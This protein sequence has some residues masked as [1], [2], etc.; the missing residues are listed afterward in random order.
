MNMKEITLLFLLIV[1]MTAAKAQTYGDEGPTLTP[2]A[3]GL[4]YENAINENIVG[5]V[6][7]HRVNYQV[8]GIDVVAHVYTPAGYDQAVMPGS[9]G[10]L[11]AASYRQ[12]RQSDGGH[13]GR[14]GLHPELSW[15]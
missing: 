4:V 3:F 8:D 1:A 5:K 7:L 6:N 9:I 14:R 11:Y 2:N 10:H 15:C 13:H 12:T